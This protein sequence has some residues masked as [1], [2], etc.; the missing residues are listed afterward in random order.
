MG[1]L[2]TMYTSAG[3]KYFTR[4]KAGK[5]SPGVIDQ[6]CLSILGTATPRHYY[7]ALTERMLSNGFFGRMNILDCCH[8]GRGK[9][10]HALQMPD[11]V[12]ETAKRWAGF[13]PGAGD[14]TNWCPEP[15]VVCCTPS[16]RKLLAE[17]REEADAEYEEARER[18]DEAGMTVWGRAHE[19]VRKLALIHA[20]SE[21][22]GLEQREPKITKA[23]VEWAGAFIMHQ[24]RRMLFM[25]ESHVADNRFD[26]QRLKFKRMLRSAPNHE[27]AHSDA[28]R[29]M[30]MRAKDF[31][32]LVGTLLESGEIVERLQPGAG[33]PGRYY[34][35]A[36]E[37]REASQQENGSG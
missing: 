10:P 23:A 24:I 37:A 35:L 31:H 13:H 28:L 34:R 32:S 11:A 8:R 7:E 22:R 12:L 3:S 19:H 20:V 2:Q 21:W 17:N 29:R 27:V 18:G 4:R 5:A 26:A 6:P 33:R 9:E 15:I 1:T 30:R 25:A 16:G 14:G 36:G